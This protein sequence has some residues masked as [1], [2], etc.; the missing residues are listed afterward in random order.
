MHVFIHFYLNWSIIIFYYMDSILNL[1]F[2]DGFYSSPISF[3][4]FSTANNARMN[5]IVY[6]FWSMY[7]FV[8]WIK[9]W[10]G[11]AESE[12]IYNF[13]LNGY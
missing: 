3:M 10:N 12:G 4:S 9:S 13:N 6:I 1:L 5:I 7:E 8:C 2:I 11:N